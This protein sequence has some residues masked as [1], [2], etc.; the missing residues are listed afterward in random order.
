MGTMDDLEI[1]ANDEG[2]VVD[3]DL[4]FSQ[5]CV[6]WKRLGR[7]AWC[8]KEHLQKVIR[9]AEVMWSRLNITTWIDIVNIKNDLET[10]YAENY[11]II[12]QV[13]M[14]EA[15]QSFV[16]QLRW[17][18]GAKTKTKERGD[19][20]EEHTLVTCSP[21]GTIK[22]WT[23]PKQLRGAREW[24]QKHHP[25]QAAALDDDEVVPT[26][27]ESPSAAD[28]AVNWLTSPALA[29]TDNLAPPPAFSALTDLGRPPALSALGE[30]P[31]LP[32]LPKLENAPSSSALRFAG[33]GNEAAASANTTLAR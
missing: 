32:P 14:F 7:N 10:A 9:E 5:V 27:A 11:P 15:H 31:A 6:K 17:R 3:L 33:S 16:R 2:E 29:L 24:D 12:L 25:P 23:S 20:R 21:D 4:A 26:P 18:K 19:A 8:N 22:I 1:T 30:L 13:A 28:A